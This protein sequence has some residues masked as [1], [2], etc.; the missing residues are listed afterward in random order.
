MIRL[1]GGLIGAVALLVS[2]TGCD[3]PGD[4]EPS[5]SYIHGAILLPNCATSNCHSNLGASPLGTSAAGLQL[6]GRESSYF[7]LTGR[8]CEGTSTIEPP[9]GNVVVPGEPERSK[10]LHLLRGD[11]VD[12]MPPDVPLP[13]AEIELI[14]RWILE[15]APC[16]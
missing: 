7:V 16:N 13:D 9:A 11:E 10:L 6:D 5:W 3:A 12:R 14:E 1:S 2:I 15:G 8:A 4:R